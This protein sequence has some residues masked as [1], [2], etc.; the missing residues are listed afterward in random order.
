[1]KT[2][3]FLKNIFCSF[4]ESEFSAKAAAQDKELLKAINALFTLTIAELKCMC[5]F[6]RLKSKGLRNVKFYIPV[7]KCCMLSVDQIIK[8]YQF[9]SS[10][11]GF[12][13]HLNTLPTTVSYKFS[14]NY[15]PLYSACILK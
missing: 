1:M 2:G 15:E 6:L 4:T 10:C 5:N 14:Q 11:R 7:N 9:I 8:F 12:F 13:Q 3:A